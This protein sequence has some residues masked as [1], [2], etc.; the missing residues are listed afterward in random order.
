VIYKFKSKASADLIM[1][2]PAGNRLV[3][4]LG[5]ESAKGIITFTECA[6][7]ITKLEAAI[8]E[9]EKTRAEA[10]AEA[11]ANGSK[12]GPQAISLRTRVWPFIEMLKRAQKAE[13]DVVWGV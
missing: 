8:A 2:E 12:L 5:K 6:S 11:A 3:A 7:A 9:E 4:L 13:A 1:L 10:E